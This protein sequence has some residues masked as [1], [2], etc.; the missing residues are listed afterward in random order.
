MAVDN[1]QFLELDDEVRGFM[2]EEIHRD[3]TEFGRLYESKSLTPTGNA[4][5]ALL[6]Q[7]AA[8]FHDEVWLADR[9]NEAGR[10][11]IEPEG[12]ALRLA[13]TEFNRYYIRAV[14]RRAE[15]HDAT[16]VVPYRARLSSSRRST[17][18]ELS[19]EPQFA[20]RILANLRG[21]AIN[22]DAESKLGQVNSGLTARCGCSNCMDAG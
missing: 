22:G 13:R 8:K 2:Q 4:D 9:L 3:L 14:C 21:R 5:Y 20:P 11:N 6:M 15:A 19:S 17:S 18:E 16:T 1:Y 12:A 7:E 10:V